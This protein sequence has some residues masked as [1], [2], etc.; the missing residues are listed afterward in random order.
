MFKSAAAKLAH[1]S[2][3]P[4]L[5]GNKA[6]RPLQD[7]ITAE[8]A[9]ITSLVRFS[10]HF[11]QASEA[12]RTWGQGEGDDLS[13]TLSTSTKLLLEFSSSLS[14]F[15]KHEQTIRE[16]MKTVRTQEENLDLLRNRRK[17]VASKADAAERKLTKIDAGQ[18][19][20]AAQS[21]LL[22]G[23]R[24]SIRELDSEIM[25]GEA[26]LGDSKRTLAQFWMTLKFG[27]LEELCRKG[28]IVAE[29]G[30]LIMAELPQVVTEPG[31]ARPFYTGNARTETYVTEA[32]R[33]L[34][35]VSINASTPTAHAQFPL[36]VNY[37]HDTPSAMPSALPDNGSVISFGRSGLPGDGDGSS[38]YRGQYGYDTS[39][40]SLGE[41]SDYDRL[42]AASQ[43]DEHGAFLPQPD[44]TRFRSLSARKP[45][46]T[47]SSNSPLGDNLSSIS[48]GIGHPAQSQAGASGRFA[49]FPVKGKDSVGQMVAEPLV[50]SRSSLSD[51]EQTFPKGDL[52]DDAPMYEAIEGTPTPP[53]GPPPGAAPPAMLHGSIY[54]GYD[55]R[56]YDSGPSFVPDSTV[57]NEDDIQLPYM[58]S[59]R[60]SLRKVP[61]GSRPLPVP[62]PWLS[63]GREAESIQE[64]NERSPSTTEPDSSLDPVQTPLASTQ[65][66]STA[67]T[68]VA[69]DPPPPAPFEDP[70]DERA[71]NAAA[72][73]EV[74]RELDSLMYQPPAPIPRD[75]SPQPL[76]PPTPTTPPKI[77]T[78][79]RSSIDSVPPA[80]SPFARA[81]GRVSGSPPV[82]RASSER[83]SPTNGPPSPLWASTP[84]SPAQHAQLPPPSIVLGRSSSPSL[85]SLSNSS[86]RTPPELPPSLGPVS[87]QRS[88]PQPQGMPFT[89][90]K[91][92]RGRQGSGMISVAAFRRPV[93]RTETGSEPLITGSSQDTSPLFVKKKDLRGSHT[94]RMSGTMGSMSSLPGAQPPEPSSSPQE[95]HPEDEFDY[96]SAYYSAGGDDPAAPPSY[97]E[98]RARSGSLR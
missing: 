6:L 56:S 50:S 30:K 80:S 53:P 20:R 29:A 54:G 13:D 42:P 96:I 12:L 15:A 68:V 28:V 90:G 58:P 69:Q 93:A 39:R 48:Q 25:T 26:K 64:P 75:P 19:D 24:N 77:H 61:F 16:H 98:S 86:F 10:L 91:S 27:G 45:P 94:P 46:P 85:T 83:P 18:K 8:K 67:L 52:E 34:D 88:L 84:S 82:P 4:S 23:L 38:Q 78:S 36:D 35:D 89:P 32:L 66:I 81:R 11:S 92:S 17:S 76:A 31:L 14:Q 71:L 7:L 72:A 59:P 2:T 62:R 44:A 43:A 57:E 65:E 70:D 49:T 74:S 37:Q 95:L 41:R 73:R 33:A 3:I 47:S 21:A 60:E 87:S 97:T 63:P 9:I 55:P 40:P 79:P 22:E 5:A 51:V 1:N